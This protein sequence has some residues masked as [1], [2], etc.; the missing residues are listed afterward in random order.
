MYTLTKVAIRYW[1]S[2][3]SM[4]PPWPGMVLAKSLILKARLN[5]LAKNPPKGPMSEAKVERAML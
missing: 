4:M 3:R 2:K 1:Q 5:P